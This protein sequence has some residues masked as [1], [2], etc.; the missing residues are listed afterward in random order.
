MAVRF[1][2][3]TYRFIGALGL[4][5]VTGVT[6][7]TDPVIEDPIEGDKDGKKGI[8]DFKLSPGFQQLDPAADNMPADNVSTYQGVELGRHLFY[9]KRL[10]VNDRISCASCHQQEFGFSDP[11]Q[12]SKGHDGSL[13]SRNSMSLVNLRWHRTFFWDGRAKTLEEQVLMPIEDPIE[14]GMDLN[15]LEK[16]LSQIELYK[17]LF[18][19]AFGS[20]TITKDRISK[21]LAQFVRTIVSDSARYDEHYQI[22]RA[23]EARLRQKLNDQEMWGYDLFNNHPNVNPVNN[24][25]GQ[26]SRGA[27]CVDCHSGDLL[28]NNAFGNNGLD[29]VVVDKGYG[30]IS[31][32]EKHMGLFK[33]PTLRNIE[34]TAPYMHDGRFATL[35]E[36]LDHYDQHVLNHPNL[37][38]EFIHIGNTRVGALDL[39]QAEKDA[40]IAYLKTF[41]DE[42]LITDPK[43]SNPFEK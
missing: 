41:T 43:F 17:G 7:C 14:M 19:N 8:Y 29:S 1:R 12:F 2:K 34:L 35:E 11:N 20:S 39:T 23:L 21:A 10:S 25:V 36:V 6:S 33:T 16:K 27:F 13:G 24:R 15:D 28:T 4:L 38:N 37:T 18:E 22:P 5:L 31:G 42:H 3:W 26:R 9:D 32:K 40:L 30:A